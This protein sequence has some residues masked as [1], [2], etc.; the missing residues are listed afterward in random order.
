[1]LAENP[2]GVDAGQQSRLSRGALGNAIHPEH[3]ID[4]PSPTPGGHF[5][6]AIG[7]GRHTK[8]YTPVGILRVDGGIGFPTPQTVDEYQDRAPF[9]DIQSGGQPGKKQVIAPLQGI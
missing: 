1:V 2:L 9:H 8:K 5:V 3:R 4:G 6:D 7:R